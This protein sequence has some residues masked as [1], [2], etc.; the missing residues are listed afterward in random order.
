MSVCLSFYPPIHV[1]REILAIIKSMHTKF[2][3]QVSVYFK[4]VGTPINIYM[5]NRNL[6][7]NFSRY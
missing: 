6:K 3:M 7:S 1:N 5:G 2:C 4:W